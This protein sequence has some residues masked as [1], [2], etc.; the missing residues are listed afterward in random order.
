VGKNNE[1]NS[2][3]HSGFPGHQPLPPNPPTQPRP[4]QFLRSALC[5]FVV[6]SINFRAHDGEVALRGF[7]RIRLE[8]E[9]DRGNA[10]GRFELG[11]RFKTLESVLTHGVFIH[12]RLVRR[13]EHK[14]EIHECWSRFRV[15]R[16]PAGLVDD[17]HVSHV[18]SRGFFVF[19]Q[20]E[21]VCIHPRDPIQ[22]LRRDGRVE[23]MNL[24]R[25]DRR[26]LEYRKS[27]VGED[28]LVRLAPRPVLARHIAV[29]G[30]GSA[31][32]EPIALNVRTHSVEAVAA[33][34]L[35]L[36]VVDV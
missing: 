14:L 12:H 27:G 34:Q 32:G 15:H 21:I 6:L 26:S 20:R 28:S 7:E 10:K 16:R 33:R 24:V 31:P 13:R 9:T 8:R 5:S 25:R 17:R 2:P 29:I 3:V 30:G 19:T 22:P 36:E 11:T 4:V 23:I 1:E 35:S 18:E